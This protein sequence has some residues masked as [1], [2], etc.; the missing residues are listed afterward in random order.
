MIKFGSQFDKPIQYFKSG[1]N[2]FDFF[3]L[4]G[5]IA[6]TG[7][8]YSGLLAIAPRLLRSLKLLTFFPSLQS[9]LVSLRKSIPS[10]GSV[11]ILLSGL[12]YVY[13]IVGNVLFGTN[14][15]VHFSSLHISLLTMFRVITLEDWTDVM[16]IQMF[17]CDAY[18]YDG[19]KDLCID[20][21]GFSLISPLF[22]ISFVFF[23]SMIIINLF[24]GIIT[25][26]IL[27]N[28]NNR[29]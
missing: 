5:L 1:W 14:D 17:G 2:L 21:S 18:G 22:F 3:I 23:G 9:I 26:Q 16:Y 25:S 11:I 20:P 13:G 27:E 4:V 24:V 6:T 19:M 15:P 28:M 8:Q 29:S 12:F 7:S 10:L